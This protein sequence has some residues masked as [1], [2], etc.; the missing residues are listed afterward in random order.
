MP[1]KPKPTIRFPS[2]P[3]IF[4]ARYLTEVRADGTRFTKGG[5]VQWDRSIYYY[6]WR[7][8]RLSE[9]Y[10]KLCANA[11]EGGNAALRQVYAD[12]GD[13]FE[14]DDTKEGFWA[15]YRYKD[16]EIQPNRAAYLFGYETYDQ[17]FVVDAGEEVDRD[18]VLLMAI[19]KGMLKR[20]MKRQIETILKREIERKRGQRL[21]SE[22]VRYQPVHENIKG[23]DTAMRV[24]QARKDN[25]SMPLWRIALQAD[26]SPS[27]VDKKAA[28]S[29]EHAADIRHLLASQADRTYRKAVAI[30][31]GVERGVFPA[32]K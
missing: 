18:D 6:W 9:R 24:Y 5:G 11:G 22:A 30:I 1:N 25:P 4:E 20:T 21:R 2:A 28:L 29:G 14:H 3:A 23:L 8:L 26:A 13:V 19:P 27:V 31:K 16:D 7:Y 32:S 15:W 10:K 12:F 17:V